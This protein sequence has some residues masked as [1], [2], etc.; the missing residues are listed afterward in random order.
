MKQREA[1]VPSL[2]VGLSFFQPYASGSKL[3]ACLMSGVFSQYSGWV[4]SI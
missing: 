4:G 2:S 1:F 3:H